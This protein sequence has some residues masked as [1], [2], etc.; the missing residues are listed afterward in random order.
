M[1]GA[2]KINKNTDDLDRLNEM[3]EMGMNNSE[4]SRI[5]RTNSGDSLSRVHI[6]QIRRGMR[7]NEDKH[8]FFMKD[9]FINNDVIKT[10]LDGD[11]YITSLGLSITYF[12]TTETFTKT[13]FISHYKN[14]IQV[15]GE[16]TQLMEIKPTQEELLRKHNT[17]IFDDISKF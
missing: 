12:P 5:F 14:S 17:F 16:N 3:F 4:I 7:W 2:S 13:H 8:S 11:E 6:S 1:I 15:D 10:N 9:D